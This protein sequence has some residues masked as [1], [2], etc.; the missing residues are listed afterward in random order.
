MPSGSFFLCRLRVFVTFKGNIYWTDHGLNLIEV[1]RMNGMYRAVVISGGLDQPR[2][3]AVHPLK[4]CVSVS[5]V[6]SLYYTEVVLIF[7]NAK[8]HPS[9]AVVFKPMTYDHCENS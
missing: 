7:S 1:A 3:I 2:A 9:V 8:L 6:S 4:G 5:R